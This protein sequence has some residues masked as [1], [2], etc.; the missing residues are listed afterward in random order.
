MRLLHAPPCW[1]CCLPQYNWTYA[2]WP[3]KRF[4]QRTANGSNVLADGH[5]T[6]WVRLLLCLLKVG[7]A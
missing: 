1:F 5:R 7:Q 2:T 3:E 6:L 4:F